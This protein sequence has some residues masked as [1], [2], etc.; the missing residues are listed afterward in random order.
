MQEV[1]IKQIEK[2][3]ISIWLI[4]I[5]TLIISLWFAYQYFSELGPKITIHFKE[6]SGLK[7]KKSH[8]KYLNLSIGTIEKITFDKSGKGIL[9]TARINN[10]AKQFINENSKFWIVRPKIDKSGISGLETLV[11]GSY[12]Q[13]Y[14]TKGEKFQNEF[15]GQNEPFQNADDGSS[16]TLEAPSSYNLDSSSLIFYKGLSVGK[17]QTLKL[18]DD[19]QVVDFTIFIKKPFDALVKSRSQFYKLS[20]AQFDIS[21]G[22]LHANLAS[23]TQ[24]LRGGIEFTS[25]GDD[26]ATTTNITY[27]LFS[28][29]SDAFT[30]RVG[31]FPKDMQE[32]K[33]KFTQDITGLDINSP[34]KFYGVQV[35]HVANIKIQ[36]NT[37]TNRLE[38]IVFVRIDTS[39]FGD[40]EFEKNIKD[41]LVANISK[42]SMILDS[43][44]VVLV[45]D[46][47][48]N[49]KEIKNGFFPTQKSTLSSVS[50]S[51]NSLVK[52]VGNLPFDKT[53]K[54]INSA[55]S[56]IKKTAQSYGENSKLSDEVSTS[57]KDISLAAKALK[58]LLFKLDKKPN[59]LIMGD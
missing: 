28:S 15:Q 27:P 39:I 35:G 48:H 26:L 6:N 5:V 10:D 9:V 20:G 7:A 30:K 24:I 11:S 14:S 59:A 49:N 13:L 16:F 3:H 18:S 42:S 52:K 2:V 54:E 17:I 37:T 55:I 29:K 31:Y 41:G 8:I 43:M 32:F 56:S 46:S 40:K 19:H 22:K 45:F 1:K 58:K 38:Q 50:E 33:M 23:F 12:I 47:K 57:L 44:E 53:L 36:H 21:N 51:L 34:V 4:P 25:Y